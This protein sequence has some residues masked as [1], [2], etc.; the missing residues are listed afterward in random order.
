MQQSMTA[1]KTV[2]IKDY[3]ASL[4]FTISGPPLQR[5]AAPAED[6]QG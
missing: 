5:R 3:C 6:S 4:F 2:G 1:I